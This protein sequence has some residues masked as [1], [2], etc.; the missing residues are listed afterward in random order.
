MRKLILSLI[1]SLV[2]TTASWAQ[3]LKKSTQAPNILTKDISGKAVDL[4]S[5]LALGKVVL[6]FYRGGWCPYC[7]TQLHQL[8]QQLMPKLKGKK[9]K[10][11][12]ISVDKVDE[13]LNTQNKHGL[14][15]SIIS[16][17][18]GHILKSYGVEFKVPKL[19]LKKF[20]THNID[21]EGAS[22]EV[23]HL[24]AT[25]AIFVI[26]ADKTIKF[27][28][29]NKNYKVRAKIRDILGSL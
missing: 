14:S 1:F 29:A 13:G 4:Y 27:S 7:N 2:F 3:A 25:P 23:H 11:Y 17:P 5:D 6:V 20:E 24:I 28:Y 10:V 9:V 22:G 16:D 8:Q 15:F 21:I 19:M 18:K 12:A 26:G